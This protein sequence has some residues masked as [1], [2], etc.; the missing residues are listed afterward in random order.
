[1]GQ[2]WVAKWVK[3]SDP[4][5]IRENTDLLWVVLKWIIIQKFWFKHEY[6]MGPLQINHS[7]QLHNLHLWENKN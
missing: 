4:N 3:I 6:R 2:L 1:M 5:L 7:L